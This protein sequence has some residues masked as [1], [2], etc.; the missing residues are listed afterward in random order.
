M[1]IALEYKCPT[2]GENCTA[3]RGQNPKLDNHHHCPHCGAIANLHF[4]GSKCTECDLCGN[5][6][7][8][9]AYVPPINLCPECLHYYMEDEAPEAQASVKELKDIE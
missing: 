1:N 6:A 5:P 9:S 7:T 8:H 3:K 2:L 4:L